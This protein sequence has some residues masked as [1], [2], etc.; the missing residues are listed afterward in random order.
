MSTSLY[1]DLQHPYQLWDYTPTH[2]QLLFRSLAVPERGYN[3]DLMFKGVTRLFVPDRLEGLELA[4]LPTLPGQH[5]LAGY[6]FAPG[7]DARLFCLNDAAGTCW[8]LNAMCFGVYH[9]QLATLE[10]SLGRYDW[11]DLGE[12]VLWYAE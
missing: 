1:S 5:P 7:H 8:Y 12:Q 9:N 6:G 11:G 4:V 3:V 2:G 10:T